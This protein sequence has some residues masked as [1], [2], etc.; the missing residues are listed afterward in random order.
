MKIVHL[1]EV[2]SGR[3]Q[4]CIRVVAGVA[5]KNNFMHSYYNT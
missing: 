2:N 4:T 5:T 1:E 3:Q